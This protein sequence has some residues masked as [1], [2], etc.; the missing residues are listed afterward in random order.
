MMRAT[1][2]TVAFVS[3][4]LLGSNVALLVE[5]GR[6]LTGWWTTKLIAVMLLLAYVAASMA[7][8]NPDEMRVAIGAAALVFDV[9]AFVRVYRAIR[10]A[11]DDAVALVVYH[12]RTWKGESSETMSEPKED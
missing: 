2:I 3:L 10:R 5:F 9:Y 11:D 6:S 1:E 4:L 12:P 7:Y 8:G